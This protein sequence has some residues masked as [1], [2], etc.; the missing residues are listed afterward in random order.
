MVIS[1]LYQGYIYLLLM[2]STRSRP[3]VAD[4]RARLDAHLGDRYQLVREPGA[5]GMATLL[6]GHRHKAG[7]RSRC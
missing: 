6:P 7:G 5:G 3:C 4:L 2:F 1:H